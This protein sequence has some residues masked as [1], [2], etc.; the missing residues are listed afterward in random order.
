MSQSSPLRFN[1]LVS[2]IPQPLIPLA[3]S[4][5]DAYSGSH[6]PAIDLSQAVPGYPPHP[7]ILRELA[8]AGGSIDSVGYGSIE[9]E[10]DLRSVYA[11]HLTEKYKA[12]VTASETQI[13][14]GCNQAFFATIMALAGPGNDVLVSNPCYF[15]HESTLAMLGIGVETFNCNAADGFSPDLANIDAALAGPKGDRIR[16]IALVSPNNPTGAVYG[17]DLLQAIYDLCAAR[18]IWLVLDETY[19]D[20]LPDTGEAPH[21]LFSNKDWQKTFIQ[22][23][24][25]SK[26]FCIPGHRV[27]AVTAGVEVIT[28][29]GKIMDNLQICATRAP[30]I[31]L[32]KTLQPMAGWRRSNTEEIG[33]RAAAFKDVFGKVPGWSIAA[34][35]AYFAYVKHPFSGTGSIA[36]AQRLA[37]DYGVLG[38]PGQFFGTGQEEYLRLAFANVDVAT[39][40]TVPSRL[41]LMSE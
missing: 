4:W 22:L 26:S 13:T 3:Q 2:R 23:Y 27:G 14:A 34:I 16:A 35:G 18:G 12:P 11:A 8:E 1:P 37:Q 19:R 40:A 33:R 9:G 36:V 41:T 21:G 15:N 29:I 39:I 5:L 20:F 17:H 31:A 10:D 32:A 30:Q 25:F 7:D 38:L 6:G 28:E 24:S